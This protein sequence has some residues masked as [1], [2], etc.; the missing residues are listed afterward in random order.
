MKKIMFILFFVMFSI[1]VYA[2]ENKVDFILQ[3]CVE[4]LYYNNDELIGF[5]T[6]HECPH[7]WVNSKR[8]DIKYTF[9][10]YAKMKNCLIVD[11]DI[12]PGRTYISLKC[13]RVK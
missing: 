4:N 8:N 3:P 7:F 12:V 10:E 1:N 9:S 6:S 11:I 5:Y 13:K 2:D